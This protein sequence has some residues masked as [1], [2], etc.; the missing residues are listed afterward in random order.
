MPEFK[1]M[2][3]AVLLKISTT[4]TD[5]DLPCAQALEGSL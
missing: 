3:H 5:K 2:E 4:L 1:P